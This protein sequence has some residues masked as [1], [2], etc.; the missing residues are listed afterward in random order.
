METSRKSGSLP[1]VWSLVV[2]GGLAG[3]CGRTECDCDVI[4]PGEVVFYADQDSL[5]GGFQRA[6]LRGAYAVRYAPP[7]FSGPADTVRLGL[8]SSAFNSHYIGLRALRWPVRTGP[9]PALQAFTGY[10]YRFVLPNANRTYDVSNLDVATDLSDGCCAC[11][12]NVRRRFVLDGKPVIA[13]GRTAETVLR[14]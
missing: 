11:P 1:G 14:R 13:E 9:Q 10:S 2:L 7:G 3:C 4:S 6:E 8:A 12:V 5:Q